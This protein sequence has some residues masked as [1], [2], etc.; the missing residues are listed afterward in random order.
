MGG[1]NSVISVYSG[2][3]PQRLPK[4][5][6]ETPMLMSRLRSNSMAPSVEASGV[7]ASNDKYCRP[8]TATVLRQPNSVGVLPIVSIGKV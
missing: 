3:Q 2:G 1:M 5:I 4:T 7:A 8:A 6:S